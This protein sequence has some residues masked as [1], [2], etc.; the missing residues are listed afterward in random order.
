MLYW[1]DV[2]IISF[3]FSVV[4]RSFI[5]KIN[6]KALSASSYR[7]LRR[8]IGSLKTFATFLKSFENH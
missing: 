1:L 6:R 2:K 3:Y 5:F 7:A 4:Y 8:A